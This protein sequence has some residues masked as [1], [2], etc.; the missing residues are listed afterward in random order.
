MQSLV[1]IVRIQGDKVLGRACTAFSICVFPVTCLPSLHSSILLLS[2][3]WQ[4]KKNQVALRAMED[5]IVSNIEKRRQRSQRQNFLFHLKSLQDPSVRLLLAM[6][7]SHRK[8]T[9]GEEYIR[10]GD[11]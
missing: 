4:D 7:W 8:I 5:D 6:T 2:R 11:Q 10:D 3:H 9:A 1:I